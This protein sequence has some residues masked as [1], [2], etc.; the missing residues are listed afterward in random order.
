MDVHIKFSATTADEYVS[1]IQE[2]AAE[3][4]AAEVDE[5]CHE[6]NCVTLKVDVATPKQPDPKQP[7]YELAKKYGAAAEPVDEAREQLRV[8]IDKEGWLPGFEEAYTHLTRC[9]NLLVRLA[10]KAEGREGEFWQVN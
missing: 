2:L 7:D 1:K 6:G 3:H 4:N 5:L 8:I 10:W 9:V